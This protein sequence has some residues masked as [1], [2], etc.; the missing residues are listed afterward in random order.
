MALRWATRLGITGAA[1]S[2]A[3]IAAYYVFPTAGT[4]LAGFY[5][6]YLG[7]TV[8][9][10]LFLRLF[11]AHG[12]LPAEHK[13]YLFDI[14]MVLMSGLQWFVIGAMVDYFRRGKRSP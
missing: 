4:F 2:A 5:F 13:P 10:R 6:N 1:I 12:I 9:L 8:G 14:F 3:L 11:G 7:G